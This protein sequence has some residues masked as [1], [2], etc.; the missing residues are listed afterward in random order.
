MLRETPTPGADRA[1]DIERAEWRRGM[2]EELAVVGMALAKDIATRL[3][4]SPYHP[5]LKHDPGRS[6]RRRAS[7]PPQ[8]DPR[9]QDGRRNLRTPQ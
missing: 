6:F 2:L 7:G 3:M 8:S 4:E 5:E 1:A 9:G